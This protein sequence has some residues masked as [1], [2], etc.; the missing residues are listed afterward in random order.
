MLKNIVQGLLLAVTLASAAAFADEASVR[1]ALQ[2]RFP[3]DKVISVTRTPYLGLY[4][5]VIGN[6]LVYTD[7]KANYLFV[8]NVL[9]AKTLQDLTE[10]RVRK[11][12]ATRFESLPLDLAMKAVKGDG[13]R[14]FAIFSDPRCPYCKRLEKTMTEVTDVTVYTFLYPIL[15]GSEPIA[16]AVWCASDRLKAWDD[17]MLREIQP[18]AAAAGCDTPIAKVMALGQQMRVNGTPTLVFASGRIVSGAIPLAELEKYL[19]EPQVK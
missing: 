6:Q 2:A 15:S 13:K 8:G 12:N 4:E 19:N 7:E 5:I 11:L 3:D 16:R 14:V 1:K 10:Q 17:L 9:D 18:R